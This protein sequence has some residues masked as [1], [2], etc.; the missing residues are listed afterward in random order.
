MS[1]QPYQIQL[2][3]PDGAREVVVYYANG[4][5]HA[6]Y[7]ARELHPGCQVSVMG[8]LPEWDGDDPL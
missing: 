1:V 8:L 2:I 3:H 7:T 5:A 6:H 4:T